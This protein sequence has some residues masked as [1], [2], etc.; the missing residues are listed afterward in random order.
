MGDVGGEGLCVHALRHASRSNVRVHAGRRHIHTRQQQQQQ[1][2]RYVLIRQARLQQRDEVPQQR[3]GRIA[4]VL[5]VQQEQMASG[6]AGARPLQPMPVATR[7]PR[8]LEAPHGCAACVPCGP[9]SQHPVR[10]CVRVCVRRGACCCEL[11]L[12]MLLPQCTQEHTALCTSRC[13]LRPKGRWLRVCPLTRRRAHPPCDACGCAVAAAAL[14]L[15]LLAGW[16]CVER[17]LHTA[18]RSSPHY[19]LHHFLGSVAERGPQ[20]ASGQ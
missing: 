12:M 20:P 13:V 7:G 8:L 4:D 9:A 16:W 18:A 6:A 14:P 19:G 17:G 5:H 11:L 3:E 15:L 2:P 1:H 10:V